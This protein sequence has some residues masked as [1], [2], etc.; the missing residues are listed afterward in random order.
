MEMKTARLFMNGR[1]QAVR[2]PKDC[3]MPGSEVFVRRLGDMVILLPRERPWAS[4][5]Q[6]LDEFSDDYMS[7]RN[8]PGQQEREDLE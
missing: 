4:L 8:Q 7:E 2:L 1:S 3:R 5:I 6:S